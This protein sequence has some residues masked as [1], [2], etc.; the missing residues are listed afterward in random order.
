MFDNMKKK[1]AIFRL[2]L[3]PCYNVNGTDEHEE[4]H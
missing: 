3:K 2:R 4:V 1:N